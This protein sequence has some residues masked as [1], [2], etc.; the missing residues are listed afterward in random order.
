M[1]SLV[2][3]SSKRS[4]YEHCRPVLKH[5]SEQIDEIAI[6]ENG[7]IAPGLLIGQLIYHVFILIRTRQGRFILLE[8]ERCQDGN[9]NIH[10][11]EGKSREHVIGLRLNKKDPANMWL[12]LSVYND[13]RLFHV[14][15]I[16]D[17]YHWDKY[18]TLNKNCIT[19][20]NEI[21]AV[22]GWPYAG[23][24]QDKAII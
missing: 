22:C 20:V 2:S 11:E 19:L 12:F 6:Y 10:K 1:G 16:V 5:E 14:Q 13:A 23:Y 8:V 21:F 17:N 3:S 7:L 24:R 15:S 18:N 9:I 4:A